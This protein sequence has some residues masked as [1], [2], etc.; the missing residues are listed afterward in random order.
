MSAKEE[1]LIKVSADTNT[2]IKEINRLNK[3][4]GS[5]TKQVDKSKT[6]VKGQKKS[7]DSLAKSTSNV[8]GLLTK[9][10]LGLG[11]MG[12]AVKGIEF[13]NMA[14]DAEQAADAFDKIVTDM[15]ADSVAVFEEIKAAAQGLI[16]DAAIKQ[17]AT[18][19][20][21]LG[22]PLEKLAQ[23]ME[24]ARAKSREMGTDAKKA[25][26]DLATGI[27]RGSPMILDNLG[28]T[29][30][31]GAANEKMA[32]S[33][34]KT[35][36]ELTK[37]EKTLA[38][39]NAVIDAGATS[40]ERY[41]DAAL[42]SKEKI[43]KMNASLDNLKVAVGSLLLTPLVKLTETT[44]KF[45]DSIDN[46]KIEDFGDDV[47]D[48]VTKLVK[49]YDI[50][51]K[52]SDMSMSDVVAGK[53]GAG[54]REWFSPIDL[55]IRRLS[56]LAR[57]FIHS[58]D[59]IDD[60][61]EQVESTA[62]A[63][64]SMEG[65]DGTAKQMEYLKSAVVS[66]IA[67]QEAL[68]Q[69]FKSS[70]P[71]KYAGEIEKLERNIN[72]LSFGLGELAIKN[73][74]DKLKKDTK[75]LSESVKK[76]TEDE[77][78][79][80]S[81]LNDKR[82]KDTEKTLKSLGKS[83]Q[84]L[85]NDIVKINQKLVKD[86]AKIANDRFKMNQDIETKIAELKRGALSE[87]AAYYDRQKDAEKALSDAKLALKA[88]EYEKYK[89]YIDQYQSLVTDSAGQEIKV[90]EQ[91]MVSADETRRRAIEG[92][93]KIQQLENAYYDK[94][95]ADAQTAHDLALQ[96]KEVELVSIEAQLVAQKA[97]LEVV[98][99]LAEAMTGKT[100]DL[101]SSAIDAAIAKV[102]Q[103]KE[104]LAT[105]SVTPAKAHVDST[106]V[107]VAKQKIEELK[108]LT[109]NG[110]TLEV[111]ANTTPADFDIKKL[112]TKTDGDEITME[113]NP[114]YEKAQKDLDA[115]RKGEAK[116]PIEKPLD[117]DTAPAKK[118]L[119]I[120]VTDME[121]PTKSE[122]TVKD[123]VPKVLS[124]ID[125]LKVTTHSTHIVHIKEVRAAAEGGLMP[126]RL[127]VGGIYRGSGSVPGYDASDSDKVNAVLTGGEYVIKR[128]A[129]DAIGVATLNAINSFKMPKI[130]GYASGGLVGGSS[131]T[132][133]SSPG[134][135]D[136]GTLTLQAG[137]N[138]YPA[139]VPREVASALQVYIDSE[140]GL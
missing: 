9:I 4:V 112:I 140:S 34:G 6:S 133:S 78:K 139:L 117:V 102:A 116:E 73:P 55:L 88:G 25:F 105:L 59:V 37:E 61:E 38:L 74:F 89:Y 49:L 132:T 67:K 10:T 51:Q 124:A 120:L 106:S 57:E 21:S 13:A 136:L 93:G 79:E 122:H 14:A 18:T 32:A 22:V 94:K 70:D 7:F 71:V 81:K 121:Q 129:V 109:L 12:I 58:G 76:Y 39:T 107:D 19:A 83:E 135:G 118:K 96:Q 24:V 77:I 23:L 54:I 80:L 41:A 5:L 126:Q 97:L 68:V 119:D 138:S 127:A 69:F 100:I 115:F 86:L 1:L 52:L 114:E 84:K 31:L 48:V 110:I 29:I 8:T 87:D 85:A 63:L 30:K 134:L 43:A 92:L 44:T 42:T 35:V 125:R 3:E 98:K 45:V 60:F 36:K 101:D 40:V 130:P 64:N 99:E 72:D 11:A 95:K 111:D 108:T 103:A 128:S 66:L 131:S 113:V 17:S 62:E 123:N 53:E 47:A 27:G 33:L 2:A 20:L 26:E 65:F 50:I 56:D 90:N 28:L 75:D 82:L 46:K 91:V 137:G 15:G 16:P 104:S